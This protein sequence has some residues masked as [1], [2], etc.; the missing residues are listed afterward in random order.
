MR[1]TVVAI[2]A[3]A[4]LAA[5]GGSVTAGGVTIL[6]YGPMTGSPAALASGTLRFLDG[7]AILEN[8]DPNGAPVG[9]VILWPPGT[10]LR[11]MD[12]KV[13]VVVGGVAATDG[14]E[15]QLGGGEYTDQSWV[16]Q[17]VG[18]VGNCRSDRYW[19]AS[20]MSLVLGA[21]RRRASLRSAH[22]DRS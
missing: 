5:C 11:V 12:D 1:G 4:L 21:G 20:T 18:E 2:I 14:D 17:L 22:V 7:C 19:L 6:R 15:V 16:E 3:A 10:D 9:V 13:H 8:I